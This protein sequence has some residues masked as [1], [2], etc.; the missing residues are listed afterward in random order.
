MVDLCQAL[1]FVCVLGLIF[2]LV[3][4]S[5][6]QLPLSLGV[7]SP[8]DKQTN[9][10]S[11]HKQINIDTAITQSIGT[12]RPEQMWHLIRVCTVCHSFSSF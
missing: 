7:T 8:V 6:S 3:L 9:K 5:S 11:F 12:D 1:L 10:F 4:P 2:L